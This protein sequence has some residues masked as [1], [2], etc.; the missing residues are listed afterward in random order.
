MR[1]DRNT[2]LF[3]RRTNAERYRR[4]LETHLTVAERLFVERR[5]AEEEEAVQQIARDDTPIDASTQ[6][7]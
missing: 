7:A 1:L 2:R 5:L 4:M 3:A 6:P